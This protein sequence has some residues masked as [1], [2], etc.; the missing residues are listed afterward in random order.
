MLSVRAAAKPFVAN[1]IS[2]AARMAGKVTSLS[3]FWVRGWASTTLPM[4]SIYAPE[5]SVSLTD[6][7]VNYFTGSRRDDFKTRHRSS[8][9]DRQLNSKD[10]SV[11]AIA[12]FLLPQVL[13]MG[14]DR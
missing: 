9:R 12:A 4:V 10:R 8:K 11:S 5:R 6:W 2:A 14:S 13:G 1:S 7:M 3:R